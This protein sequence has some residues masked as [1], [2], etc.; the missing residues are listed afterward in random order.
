MNRTLSSFIAI[1]EHLRKQ[2]WP[3]IDGRKFHLCFDNPSS[4]EFCFMQYMEVILNNDLK[5]ENVDTALSC[6]RLRWQHNIDDDGYLP[7]KEYVLIPTDS[8]CGLVQLLP[9]G[10]WWKLFAAQLEKRMN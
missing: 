8:F 7:S 6:V 5:V 3:K 4:K 9:I 2:Q 1:S 10:D